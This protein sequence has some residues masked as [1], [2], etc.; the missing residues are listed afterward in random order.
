VALQAREGAGHQRADVAVGTG[1]RRVV[2]RSGGGGN[3]SDGGRREGWC[4]DGLG[5]RLTPGVRPGDD[6]GLILFG[7]SS[8]AYGGRLSD[9]ETF[10]AV[11]TPAAALRAYNGGHCWCDPPTPVPLAPLTAL[12]GGTRPRVVLL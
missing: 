3:R 6:I 11:P 1:R 12:L 7:G 2:S 10:P 8:L 9:D 4:D 5:F